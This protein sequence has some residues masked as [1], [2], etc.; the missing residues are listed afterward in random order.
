VLKELSRS[1]VLL[2]LL[3]LLLLS[4]IAIILSEA[5]DY[6]KTLDMWVN[7]LIG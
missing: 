5:I 3:L 1:T 6:L 4:T 2:L 7:I